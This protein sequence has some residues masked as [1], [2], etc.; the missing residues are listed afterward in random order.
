MDSGNSEDSKQIAFENKII[1]LCII[2]ILLINLATN[3]IYVKS[4]IK[5]N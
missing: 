1:K 5:I 2:N 4:K 3:S